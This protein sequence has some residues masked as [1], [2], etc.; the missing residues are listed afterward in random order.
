ME[1]RPPLSGD[2]ATGLERLG[3]SGNHIRRSSTRRQRLGRVTPDGRGGDGMEVRAHR[4]TR[5]GRSEYK[6]CYRRENAPRYIHI[7]PSMDSAR[8]HSFGGV[9]AHALVVPPP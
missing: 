8:V 9:K 5:K 3:S 2:V 4:A 6:G 1:E 7:A